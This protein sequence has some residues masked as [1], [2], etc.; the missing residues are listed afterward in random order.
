M[1]TVHFSFSLNHKT[2]TTSNG[3]PADHVVAL[4]F[5]LGAVFPP[6]RVHQAFADRLRGTDVTWITPLRTHCVIDLDA[7]RR[8]V[9]ALRGAEWMQ[10]I[11]TIEPDIIARPNE[12]AIGS[13]ALELT[14]VLA[15]VREEIMLSQRNRIFLSHRSAR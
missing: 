7:A 4:H 10:G 14:S 6:N 11:A 12:R 15:L 1:L 13:R 9:P 8:A 5:T 2:H 3:G